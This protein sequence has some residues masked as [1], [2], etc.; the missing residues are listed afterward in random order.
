M[1]KVETDKQKLMKEEIYEW[2]YT[3]P[4]CEAWLNYGDNYC[5]GCGEKLEWIGEEHD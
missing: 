3:C 1:I 5:K 2:I 4:N